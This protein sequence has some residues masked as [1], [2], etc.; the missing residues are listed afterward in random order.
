ME[1]D[2]IQALLCDQVTKPVRFLEAVERIQNDID[3]FIEVGPGTT[4]SRLLPD[5]TSQPVV[6]TDAGSSSLRGILSA[7]ATAF[8]MG[9]VINTQALFAHRFARPIDLNWKPTF[10]A[11]PCEQAPLPGIELFER[12]QEPDAEEDVPHAEQTT[13]EVL[14]QIIAKHTELPMYLLDLKNRMLSDLHLN[15]ITVGQILTEA[16]RNLGISPSA[17]LLRYADA[18]LGEIVQTLDD[19]QQQQGT[20]RPESREPDGLAPWIRCFSVVEQEQ[21][22][23]RSSFAQ[24]TGDW[25]LIAPDGYPLLEDLARAFASI[26]GVGALICL[27]ADLED[28][29]ATLLLQGATRYACAPGGHAF[30]PA[31]AWKHRCGLRPDALS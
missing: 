22:L 10:F 23:S 13:L 14:R 16:S 3:L 20:H 31:P 6:A 12:F 8:V 21:A 19:L 11:N 26:K 18:R 24:E 2:H 28:G 27:P 25:Q 9:S 30:C 5:I 4:L 15:S 1:D 29:A 17:S 7:T